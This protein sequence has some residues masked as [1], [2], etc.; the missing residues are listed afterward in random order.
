MTRLTAGKARHLT[1]ADLG[2]A[3]PGRRQGG[4]DLE[5][6]ASVNPP[7]PLAADDPI[8]R[9]VT[10]LLGDYGGVLFI[11]PP[12]TSKSHYAT[13]VAETLA[14]SPD[15]VLTVQF[16]PSYQYEDFM[17]GY[18]AT[19]DEGMQLTDKHF[20]VICKA[21]AT[22]PDERYFLVIDE[23]S[24]ADPGRVFGE[25][26]TYIERSK[27]G[28]TFSL[29][30]GDTLS[31]PPNLDILATMNPLDRGVDEVDAAPNRRFAKYAM[32]PSEDY[33]NTFLVKAGMPDLLRNRVLNF[34]RKVN[35]TATSAANPHAALGHTYFQNISGVPD[36]IRLWD[37]QLRFHFEQAYRLDNTGFEVVR[38]DWNRVIEVLPEELLSTVET[39]AAPAAEAAESQAQPSP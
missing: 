10:D 1:A 24:R 34:F 37:H 36:L 15:R 11:G 29:A 25:A 3:P 6:A 20:V 23:L 13:L 17:Q 16:H 9:T 33:L 19:R 32:D 28:Q 21:A 27:R 35:R 18:V 4:Q 8:L 22:Y 14:G 26:L 2:V 38:N 31:V 12:G 7:A 39:E 30:S 5:Q